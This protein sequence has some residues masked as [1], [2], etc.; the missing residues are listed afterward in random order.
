MVRAFRSTLL[1]ASFL[2]STAAYAQQSDPQS[3][4]APQSDSTASGTVGK[5]GGNQEAPKTPDALFGNW[6]GLRT[7]LDDDGI[8]VSLGYKGEAAGNVSGGQ[9]KDATENGQFALTAAFDTQKI[10]GL[11]GGTFQTTITFRQGHDL[12]QRA[13]LGTLQQV[14]EVYGRGQTWRL[15]ELWYQQVLADGAVVL[16]VGRMPAGEFNTFDCDFQNLTFCGAPAG[17]ITGNYW[18]NYP[19]AQWTGWAKFRR[20]DFYLKLGANEDN[21]NN[22][23]NAFF[24]SRGG[25]QG[26]ILHAEAGWTPGFEGKLPGRFQAGFWY[27]TSRDQDALL[28][29]NH[30]PFAL[31]GLPAR[32]VK[33]QY[34]MYI[35]GEQQ[36]TGEGT[37][38][39]ISGV[40]TRKSGLNAFFN[41]TRND[42]ATSTTLDQ[43][44]VGLYLNKP[45]E[46][47]PDDQVGFAVGR[48]HYNGRAARAL[49]LA[50]P[51]AEKPDSEYAMELYYGFHAIR[52]VVL[53]PNVQYIID[54]GGYQRATDVVVIGGRFDINF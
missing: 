4:Q 30:V 26:A 8:K 37:E 38:D 31:S 17:N 41:A 39:P 1:A 5:A 35:Q 28:D 21:R 24:F 52:G 44:T 14:Q 12:D 36:L 42:P 29:I 20:G 18:F 16:K 43:E 25:A 9:R 27:N 50:T 40:I 47:R 3:P 33:G 19:I 54:P 51:G 53:R 49:I 45:F 48:T 15:T 2:L 11:D 6:S 23:D 32:Y 34:G 10:I 7:R 13:G 46:S 22:L